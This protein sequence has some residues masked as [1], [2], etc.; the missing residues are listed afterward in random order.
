MKKSSYNFILIIIL[1][2]VSAAIAS[3]VMPDFSVFGK[4]IG[5][6]LRDLKINLGL[7][8]KGG[9]HLVYK[10]DVS[11]V[12]QDNI[13]ESL[14]GARD[15]IERRVNAYGISE[16]QI[17]TNKSGDQYRLIVDLAGVKD[18]GEA[19]EMIGKTP[20]LDFRE[21]KTQEDYALTEEEKQQF[22]LLNQQIEKNAQKTLGL[23]KDGQNFEETAKEVSQ[24][25]TTKDQG[26]DLGFVKKGQLEKM[27]GSKELEDI[28]FS[29][30]FEVGSV[31]PELVKSKIG[32]HILK[33]IEKKDQGDQ[34]QV[35]LSHIF[36]KTFSEE[37]KEDFGM[38]YKK[39]KLTGKYLESAQAGTR[40]M[41]NE[42]VVILKFDS[43]GTKLFREIT[44]RNLG[45]KV[46]IFLDEMMISNPT[47]QTVIPDGT[48][49][50][51]G[52]QNLK[53]AQEMAKNL[54]AG[55]LP[56]P[57]E[58]VSQE[59]VGA[60][61]GQESLN[62]SLEAGGLGLILVCAFMLVF[63]LIFGA[64]AIFALGIYALMMVSVFKILGITLTLSGIAGFILSLGLAVDANILIFERIKEEI[65]QGKPL[66]EAL[67]NGFKKAWSSIR[68]GNV[69]TIITCIVLIFFGTGVVKGFATT[70]LIGVLLSMF[71]AVMITR[72]VLEFLETKLGRKMIWGINRKKK[73]KRS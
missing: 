4:N 41:S 11:E 57:I 46:P 53:E 69:S 19:I 32:L 51:T 2:V 12:K 56:I 66:K 5:K 70:L 35:K 13:M 3:P 42:P 48:A 58:L 63:Y 1:L 24:D 65:R 6:T 54:N 18:V 49:E 28:V 36:F 14:S 37:R 27:F 22:K 59:N 20:T 62:K 39:T 52:F 16:P 60:S 9:A 72:N 31:W 50:L 30:E 67:E 33:K 64:V 43:Q 23:I 61:L 29:E 25:P 55:A 68:D 15:I 73:K 71:T 8:L 17:V 47:V 44:E 34:E 21:E 7:D 40:D 45:K 26:G 10:A 38:P